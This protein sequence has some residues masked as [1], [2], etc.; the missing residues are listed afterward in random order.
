VRE[1]LEKNKQDNL[2]HEI[3]NYFSSNYIISIQTVDHNITSNWHEY[4]TNHSHT[5]Y[6]SSIHRI[7]KNAK[8]IFDD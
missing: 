4:I 7:V 5:D 1:H 2:I 8:E 3:M 6:K